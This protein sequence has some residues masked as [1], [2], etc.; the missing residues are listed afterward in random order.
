MSRAV[1]RSALAYSRV[2]GLSRSSGRSHAMERAGPRQK[3]L[4]SAVGAPV[5]KGLPADTPGTEVDDGGGTA[6]VARCVPYRRER[7]ADPANG[8]FW[9]EVNGNNTL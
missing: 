1:A 6:R 2:L 7:P 9:S 5:R 3:G 4:M 8:V